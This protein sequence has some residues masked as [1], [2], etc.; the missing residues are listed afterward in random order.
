MS[1][2][3]AKLPR[4]H[5]EDE[6]HL[7]GGVDSVYGKNVGYAISTNATEEEVETICMMLNYFF[8]EEGS[9]LCNYGV[10]DETFTYTEGEPWYTDMILN[11]PEGLTLIQAQCMY[12]GYMVPCYC[13]FTKYNITAVSTWKSLVDVWS[14]ADNAYAIPEISL[15]AEEQAQYNA[16]SADISTYLDE[17]LIKFM[18]GDMNIN[19]DAVWDEY[20]STM[21]KLG[22][23]D[24]IDAYTT[25]ME[26]FRAI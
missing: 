16:V 15:T 8:T 22:V 4:V 23:Q 24:M 10:E 2:V 25:A 13:D 19:D 5:E 21:E 18:I 7:T 6:I 11:N 3:A 14:S 12:L 17:C 1:Y 26:R 20:L 9:L